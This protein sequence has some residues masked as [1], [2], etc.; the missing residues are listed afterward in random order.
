MTEMDEILGI[1]M[2]NAL[3]VKYNP[4]HAIERA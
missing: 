2:R 1:N 3:I 4:R